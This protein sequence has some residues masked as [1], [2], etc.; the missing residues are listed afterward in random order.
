M[1]IEWL[2][3]DKRRSPMDSGNNGSWLDKLIAKLADKNK[4]K[5]KKS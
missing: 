4:G 1:G 5:K 3:P 2:D